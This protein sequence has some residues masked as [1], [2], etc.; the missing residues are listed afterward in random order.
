MPNGEKR[1]LYTRQNANGKE[2]I[3]NAHKIGTVPNYEDRLASFGTPAQSR[4]GDFGLEHLAGNPPHG[5]TTGRTGKSDLATSESSLHST[6]SVA[7]NKQNVNYAQRTVTAKTVDTERLKT[8]PTY[9]KQ[10]Q[11]SIFA[12]GKPTDNELLKIYRKTVPPQKAV[13]N[14]AKV[15]DIMAQVRAKMAKDGIDGQQAAKALGVEKEYSAQINHEMAQAYRETSGPI[16]P[17][18]VTKPQVEST[19]RRVERALDPNDK[20]AYKNLSP[21][22]K[23]L[24][25]GEKAKQKLASRVSASSSMDA[26]TPKSRSRVQ[27]ALQSESPQATPQ[28]GTS[29]S[30]KTG[31]ISTSSKENQLSKT[32]QA[33][34]E[35]D[36][37]ALTAP[38]RSYV[39]NTTDVTERRGFTQ[40]V[41]NSDEVSTQTKRKV[42]GEYNVRS[43]DKL[44]LSADDFSRG[45]LQKV[46]D[47]VNER[48]DVKK[49]KITDQDVAD[50]LAVAKR[51]DAQQRFDQS[52]AI[53]D[54]LAQHGTASGQTI[55]AFSLLK[56]RTP[57]GIKYQMIRDLKKAG[58]NLT[59]ADQKRVGQLI[60]NVRKTKPDTDARN[61]ALFETMDY[62]SRR[63]PNNMGDKLVN[64]WR[65]GL[66]TAPKTTGGNI[67]GNASE[68]AARELWANPVAIATDKFFSLF[69]GKRTKTMSKGTAAGFKEGAVKGWDYMKTG[70]DKRNVQSKWDAPRRVNYNNKVVDTYVNGV[71]RWMGT[72]DQPFYYGAKAAAAHDLAK[73]DGMNLKMKGQELADYI[74]KAVSDENWKPQTFK[75]AKDVE[76]YARYAVY[77]NDTLLGSMAQGIKK[78][79]DKKGMRWLTD[80]ILPFTQVPSSIAMRV[81]DRTPIGTARELASQIRRGSFDQRAMAEAI[82]NGSFGIPVVATGYALSQAGEITGDYPLVTRTLH[83][84]PR[85]Y[86]IEV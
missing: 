17:G 53:Y 11:D 69:T 34:S 83:S 28:S 6:D 40:S 70:Y 42:S 78:A 33:V 67:I 58:V 56:N 68:V 10:V 79:A 62:V 31:E 13:D 19:S 80:F 7:K 36:T 54:K 26:G 72:Q 48:L 44:A 14:T 1:V 65:A 32:N 81:I 75:T 86:I 51:L 77:Q 59:D 2:E 37:K 47:N 5:S 3:I 39:D 50:S 45:N 84:T 64:F 24:Y 25:Q 55:Q 49:G 61:R 74:E 66:L 60:D 63:V 73:A 8:D 76:Q 9:Q 22:E 27:T 16:M 35:T 57:E 30:L 82:G 21:L 38:D 29:S 43:T 85:G 15:P 41:K 52:Q 20:L 23:K 12:S 18:G 71:Y 46:T 4:T